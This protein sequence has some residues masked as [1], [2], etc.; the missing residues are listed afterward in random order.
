MKFWKRILPFFLA[1]LLLLTL[2]ACGDIEQTIA[3]TVSDAV[4]QALSDALAD[5]GLEDILNTDLPAETKD[6]EPSDT[7]PAPS[8]APDAAVDP[9]PSAEPEAEESPAPTPEAIP[10]L[11]EDGWYT[12]KDDVAEYLKLYRRLP[13]NFMTKNEA[14]AEYGWEGG[15]LPDKRSI[16]GDRFGNREGLLPTGYT[17]TEC[18]IDTMGKKSRGA[19]RIVFAITDTEIH[20]YYTDDHYE[21]FSLLYEEVT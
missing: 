1:V 2:C 7:Q 18:D 3:D 5:T 4:N 16:G 21:S 17:Y 19:K 15:G 11:A 6:P 10:T 14:K 12:A 9:L 13:D 8:E 20:I